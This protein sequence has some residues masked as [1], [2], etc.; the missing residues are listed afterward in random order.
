MSNPT[1]AP[2]EHII[3]APQRTQSGYGL[4]ITQSDQVCQASSDIRVSTTNWTPRAAGRSRGSQQTP[5]IDKAWTTTPSTAGF[6]G[7]TQC[8]EVF[9]DRDSLFKGFDEVGTK[10]KASVHSLQSSPS[11]F[12][13][14]S[15]RSLLPKGTPI[16]QD[17]HTDEHASLRGHTCNSSVH[18][19]QSMWSWPAVGIILLALFSTVLSGVFFFVAAVGP[20]YG[21][22]VGT[23]GS[24]TASAAAFVTSLLAKLIEISFVTLVVALIG[25]MIA[26]KAYNKDSTQGVTLAEMTMRSW[27]VQPG[28]IFSHWES[29]QYG[30]LSRLGAL[31]LLAAAV[32]LLYTSA[33]TALV[34]PQ[35]KFGSPQ[36]RVLQ[37]ES[38]TSAF[39]EVDIIANQV[40][41][42]GTLLICQHRLSSA[43]MQVSGPRSHRRSRGDRQVMSSDPACFTGVPQ[44]PE[45]DDSVDK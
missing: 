4:G 10:P 24:L 14:T 32:A 23:H 5:E 37:C 39:A 18:F 3:L 27:A 34:Q 25:Q 43:D 16:T 7:I 22:T 36:L 13:S 44:L 19:R 31:T 12:Q 15:E 33:A 30:A 41:S 2:E 38:F 28:T 1:S 8:D 21:R 20:K 6:S 29:V 42:T 45:L 40:C 9:N 11:W 26:R 17:D 35:L